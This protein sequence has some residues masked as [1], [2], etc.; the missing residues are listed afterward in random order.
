P[1]RPGF[2]AY[3]WAAGIAAPTCKPGGFPNSHIPLNH[4]IIAPN[5][6]TVIDH[7]SGE[8]YTLHILPALDQ[9]DLHELGNVVLSHHDPY[10][11]SAAAPAGCG[12]HHQAASACA[13][14][15][16]AAK[17]DAEGPQRGTGLERR[18]GAAS[19]RRGLAA[20]P[21]APAASPPNIPT[22]CSP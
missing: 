4:P 14:K 21:G 19:P 17:V 18:A 6:T 9:P 8:R 11:A 10:P 3:T 7:I 16:R 22:W 5:Q 15:A 13:K 1:Q 20:P 12:E 2:E